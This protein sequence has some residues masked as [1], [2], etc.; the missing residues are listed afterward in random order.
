MRSKVLALAA[1]L[2][3]G[4]ATM[5]TGAMAFH[6]GGGGGGFHGGGGGFGGGCARGAAA[7]LVPQSF[8]VEFLS[9]AA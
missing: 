4:T 2:T 8:K 7:G 1:A 5:T 9:E 3:I 6:G